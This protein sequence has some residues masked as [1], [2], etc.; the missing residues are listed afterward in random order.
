[1]LA[2]VGEMATETEAAGWTGPVLVLE[3][4]PQAARSATVEN[5]KMENRL[6]VAGRCWG[7]CGEDIEDSLAWGEGFGELDWGTD[8]GQGWF[9]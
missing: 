3:V 6:G 1:M 4:V 2:V 7:R 9:R 5:R 8:L